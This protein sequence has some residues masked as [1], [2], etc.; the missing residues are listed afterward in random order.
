MKRFCKLRGIGGSLLSKEDFIVEEI[1][2]RK[3]LSPYSRGRKGV[4][5]SAGPYALLKLAKKGMTTEE[6]INSVAKIYG[7]KKKAIGF[8]GLKDRF[9]VTTQ[10]LTVKDFS[11]KSFCGKNMSVEI[12]GRAQRPLGIGDLEGNKFEITLRNCEN[13]E[14]L[15][16]IISF[17][18][19]KGMPN[20]FGRQRFGTHG[21][22]YA[23][24]RHL[25][26]GRFGHALKI[27]NSHGKKFGGIAEAGRARLKFFVN[28]YQSFLFNEMLGAYIRAHGKP[29]YRDAPIV[30]FDTKIRRGAFGKLLQ[31][32]LKK[33]KTAPKDFRIDSLRLCCLGSSRPAFV[34]PRIESASAEGKTVRLAFYLP[35]GSYATVLIKEVAG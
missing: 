33:E 1:L 25:V 31:A 26:K 12:A 3:F 24:G 30:G 4:T 10:Y 16:S 19:E 28:A 23:V 27:I 9:A 18:K 5:R 14:N 8:A 15:G 20:Y 29:D 35:R 21:D 2:T 17:L 13:T 34:M 6:A 32:G 11:G 7:V 22:N